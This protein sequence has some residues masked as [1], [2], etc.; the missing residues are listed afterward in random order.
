MIECPLSQQFPAY[1]GAASFLESGRKLPHL[2]VSQFLGLGNGSLEDQNLWFQSCFFDQFDEV[3]PI[4]A[5]QPQETLDVLRTAS[6]NHLPDKLSLISDTES[7]C[8]SLALGESFRGKP[9]ALCSDFV[10]HDP[11]GIQDVFFVEPADP[12]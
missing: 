5:V 4:L 6:V 7:K 11:E 10:C 9:F 1:Q 2:L 12:S 3:L 8:A